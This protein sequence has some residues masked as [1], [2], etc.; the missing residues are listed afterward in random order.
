METEDQK[1]ETTHVNNALR[2]CGYPDWSFKEVR[3]REWTIEEER[4]K[5]QKE[6]S[7][8]QKKIMITI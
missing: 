7:D 2:V 6:K 8:G 1:Q 3:E 5:K 4:R